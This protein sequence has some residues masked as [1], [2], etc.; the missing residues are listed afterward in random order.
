MAE[1]GIV[2]P[3]PVYV[4]GVGH[5]ADA[6][7][8]NYDI[9]NGAELGQ[10]DGGTVVMMGRTT[11]RMNVDTLIPRKGMKARLFEALLQ[12]KI[13][14]VR[15]PFDGKFHVFSGIIK[16]GGGSWEFQNGSCKGQFGFI[17]AEPKVTG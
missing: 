11:C 5:I 13:V 6:T 14:R 15:L 3:V 12:K 10:T 17:G 7:G 8:G 2:T 4:E 16:T 1:F 9:D